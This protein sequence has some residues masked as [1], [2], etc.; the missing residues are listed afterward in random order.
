MKKINTSALTCLFCTLTI[1]QGYATGDVSGALEKVGTFSAPGRLT[2][3][4]I[5]PG[6]EKGS[7]LL[8]LDYMYIGSTLEIVAVN[9]KTGD[10][11]NFQN[12]VV[13]ESGAYGLT[14]GSDGNM[15]MGTLPHA[16][17]Y[18]LDTKAQK[19]EDLGIP[20]PGEQYIWDITAAKNK[21]IYGVTYPNCKLISYDPT[22]GRMQDLGRIDPN[23]KYAR[24]IV[25]GN[26]NLLYISTGVVHSGIY[27][28]D[29]TNGSISQ[30]LPEAYRG[31]GFYNIY[32]GANG[33]IYATGLGNS[34]RLANGIAIK[35][36]KNQKVAPET[37]DA[38]LSNR[39]T[40]SYSGSNGG[41]HTD[42]SVNKRK[43]AVSP[44]SYLPANR[45]SQIFRLTAAPDGKLYGSSVLPLYFFSFDPATRKFTNLGKWGGGEVYSLL[46]HNG[47]ILLASYSAQSVLM[48]YDP[49]APVKP[50]KQQG[51]NPLY[52]SYKGADPGWRPM[53]I[54]AGKNGYI[55]IG[56][57][58]GYGS[59]EG[60]LAIWNTKTNTVQSLLNLI[61]D[62]SISSLA[63][64]K[65]NIIYGG[66]SVSGGA[67]TKPTQ[68]DA[69]LFI[70]DTVSRK[71][72][73]R[74]IP[75]PGAHTITNLIVASD[76]QL[77]GF[78]DQK[79]FEYDPATRHIKQL[80]R[81]NY[82]PLIYN[83]IA[84]GPNNNLYG[85]ASKGIYVIDPSTGKT[86]LLHTT[87]KPITSGGALVGNTFYFGST[88]DIYQ[89]RL[90]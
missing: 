90:P 11:R 45:A 8:Y 23:E 66:T 41:L 67:G 26:G 42:S 74:I 40:V 73:S 33:I 3:A 60:Q 68:K 57:V 2:G 47:R 6:A 78:A 83:S 77:F 38:I 70:F 63:A 44:H 52:V 80:G 9:P 5:G 88:S 56:A 50:G 22:T 25:S 58:A 12:P 82:G 71:V 46:A 31:R 39:P 30:I 27:T 17:L 20:A 75:V 61:P 16:H 36:S 55:Y 13:T 72:T 79:L 53:A 54:T 18:R 29:T 1:A 59:L 49:K 86:R 10:T 85:L 4:V 19:L 81:V 69:V 64:G 89:Y 51:S 43:S 21:K 76:G 37:T 48:T 32:R 24:Y 7:Q 62:Q 35:L 84:T 14:L 87:P 65:M 28:Y 15:Y 34:F